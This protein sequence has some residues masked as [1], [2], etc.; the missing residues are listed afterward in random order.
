M[1]AILAFGLV[2]SKRLNQR[3]E[4]VFENKFCCGPRR[5][6][7]NDE[8]GT[9]FVTGSELLGVFEATWEYSHIEWTGA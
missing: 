2:R 5:A 9:N 3:H 1:A 8:N 7:K 4:Y 6:V